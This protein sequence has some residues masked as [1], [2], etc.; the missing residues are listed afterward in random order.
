MKRKIKVE[1]KPVNT[2]DVISASVDELRTAVGILE[3][4]P[5]PSVVSVAP[6]FSY[7]KFLQST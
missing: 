5:P 7:V 2:N 3:L 1:I 6:I 4:P